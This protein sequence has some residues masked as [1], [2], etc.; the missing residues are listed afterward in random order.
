MSDGYY[1]KLSNRMKE[2]KEGGA[3]VVRRDTL[4]SYLDLSEVDREELEKRCASAMA[5]VI[6]YQ[7]G[8]RSVVRGEGL[9]LNYKETNNPLFLQKLCENSNLDALQKKQ[10]AEGLEKIKQ[11]VFDSVPDYA[12]IALGMDENGNMHFYEEITSDEIVN[13]LEK[14][15]M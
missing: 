13:M 7:A 6:L 11:K 15:A 3:V 4:A 9:F 12:Q 1:S 5:S 8:Y 10:V 2:L 14:L